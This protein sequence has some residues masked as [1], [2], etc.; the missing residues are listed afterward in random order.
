MDRIH[1]RDGPGKM[2]RGQGP[3][4]KLSLTPDQPPCS[5]RDLIAP[6][7][8]SF[9]ALGETPSTA[10]DPGIHPLLFGDNP[11][12]E[13]RS[14]AVHLRVECAPDDGARWRWLASLLYG[15]DGGGC[16]ADVSEDSKP[17]GMENLDNGLSGVRAFAPVPLSP[18]TGAAAMAIPVGSGESVLVR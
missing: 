1:G 10:G 13:D 16:S 18:L 2:K 11:S 4:A 9:A 8:I 15:G 6:H 14:F 7:H 5:T 3:P 12:W 17:S